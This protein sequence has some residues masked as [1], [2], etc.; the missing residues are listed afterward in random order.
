MNRLSVCIIA[1]NEEENL[2]QLLESAQPVAD[3]I[4]VVDGGSTDRTQEVARAA[5]ARV[6]FRAFTAHAD[7]KNYA[8]SLASN[9]WIFLLD[10]DEALSDDLKR[11]VQQ[12]KTHAPQFAVYE[13]SR[14]TWYLGSWIRHSRWYP[15]WQRRIYRRDSASFKGV[16]HSALR[17]D[18]PVGR[19]RG[20]L[21]HYT[22]RTFP[23]HEAK[24]E[25]Y[26][27]S[28]AQEMFDQGRRSW[29]AAMWIA[30]PWSWVHHFLL[31]AGF[32]DGSRGFLIA[33]MAARGV[34]MKFQ[35]LGRLVE[36]EK[37]KNR[38]VA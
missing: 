37:L 9:D 24:V 26:T 35:K 23:E 10:A 12:W 16:I 17:Y 21:F 4:I 33:R 20:D 38:G 28:V 31:G 3:E 25:K 6:F 8:A 14:L 34:R 36:A 29:R 19:L 1:Q 32:L 27:T 11:S 30:A 5:G 22:V 15:D 18:G 13:M 7:Q 2:P